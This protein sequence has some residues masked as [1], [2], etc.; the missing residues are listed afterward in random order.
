MNFLIQHF[1]P[2][3]LQESYRAESANAPMLVMPENAAFCVEMFSGS[4]E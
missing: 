2:L 1:H 4:C 3:P